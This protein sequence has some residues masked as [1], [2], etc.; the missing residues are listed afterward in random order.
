MLT[1]FTT[2]NGPLEVW[3]NGSHF[4]DPTEAISGSKLRDPVA[5][6]GPAG[7]VVVRDARMW[8]RGTPNR[9]PKM[10]PMLALT[11]QR[12]WFRFDAGFMPI[13]IEEE[14][15]RDW[16]KEMQR[17]FRFGRVPNDRNA[18]V[19]REVLFSKIVTSA[20]SSTETEFVTS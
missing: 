16:P 19:I 8:H 13:A 17:L 3:P 15:Y 20:A 4:F 7:S 14:T 6:I 5:V 9:T 2:E 11:F 18:S 12:S 1:D 10:R